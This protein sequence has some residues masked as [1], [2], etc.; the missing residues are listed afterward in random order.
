MIGSMYSA[1]SGLQAHQTKMDVIGNNIANVNTYGYKTNRATFADVFYSTRR[2][3][4]Q[5]NANQGGTNPSQIGYGAKVATIDV[6]HT[7]A[8][9]A[10][11]NRPLDIYINGDGFIAVKTADGLAKYTRAGVLSIDT[12]GNLVDRNGNMV[13]GLPLDATTGMP[14]LDKDGK[15]T[16]QSM[17]P[18]KLDPSIEYTGIEISINGEVVAMKPGPPTFTPAPNT[19]WMSGSQ[20]VKPDSLYSGEVVLT[21]KRDPSATTAFVPGAYNSAAHSGLAGEQIPA[22]AI[23]VPTDADISGKLMLS[24]VKTTATTADYKLTGTRADGTTFE[25]TSAIHTPP[26][27]YGAAVATTAITFDATTVGGTGN[28]TVNVVNDAAAPATITAPPTD[29]VVIADAQEVSVTLG[30]GVASTMTVTGYGYEKSGNRVDFPSATVNLGG[31]TPDTTFVM[32]DVTFNIDPGTFGALR[33]GVVQNFT[34]GNVAA[35]TSTPVKLGQVAVVTFY[36]QDGLSQEGEDYYLETINSGEPK[37]YVP[38]RSGTGTLLAGAL[39]MSNVDL[40]REFTEM[41]ITE[42]GFQANTRMVTVSDE[43]LQELI[44]MKR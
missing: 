15:A 27:A 18:V 21:I 19:G 4:S 6:I 41:I 16:I 17:V 26:A 10:T 33:D 29:R 42:R 34:V 11:T 1:V 36:N 9:A 32:G 44:N 31:G 40:S 3:A 37:G 20:T 35:G 13:L 25:L 24:V 12:A 5:P 14:K 43:M 30:N 2:A 23:T 8:G 7:R 39:E 28:I 38:G 22:S